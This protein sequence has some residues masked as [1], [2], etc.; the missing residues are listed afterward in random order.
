MNTRSTLTKF[1]HFSASYQ[2]NDKIAGHNYI[3]GVTIQSSDE[4]GELLLVKRIE[5]GLIQKI[6]SRDLGT[7][8]D[9]FKNSPISEPFMLKKFWELINT[10]IKPLAVISLSLER[11]S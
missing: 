6:Q 1:F 9:F 2:K 3:L 7:D 8:V 11:D 5:E 4:A 10:L